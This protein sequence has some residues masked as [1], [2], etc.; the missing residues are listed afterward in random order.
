M[1]KAAFLFSKG[2]GAMHL[3]VQEVQEKRQESGSNGT[4]ASRQPLTLE[5]RRDENT[6]NI[7]KNEQEEDLR[8][9]QHFARD[10]IERSVNVDL[11]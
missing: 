8:I 2:G 3:T 6:A 9:M 4:S 10:F 5:S 7:A 1:P 11:Y